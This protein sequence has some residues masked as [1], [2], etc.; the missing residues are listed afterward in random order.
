MFELKIKFVGFQTGDEFQRIV[1]NT[2]FWIYLLKYIWII[3]YTF[4][5]QQINF[6][7]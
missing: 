5:F 4:F 1:S 6:N 3:E 7:W 2:I